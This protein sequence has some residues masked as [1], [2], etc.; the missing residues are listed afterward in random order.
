M[1]RIVTKGNAT[2]K[3]RPVSTLID[4][5]PVEPTQP[6]RT[7]AH[8]TK[9]SVVSTALPGPMRLFHQPGLRSSMEF[10]PAQ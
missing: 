1:S 10:T 6:P 2:P 9:K 7:L 5:G 4:D 3:G 8:T